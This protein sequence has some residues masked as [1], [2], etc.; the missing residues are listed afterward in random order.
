MAR[1]AFI[2]LE[3]LDRAGKSTQVS[4]I[5]QALKERNV[6][7]ESRVFPGEIV[8]CYYCDKNLSSTCRLV[9]TQIMLVYRSDS[10][11]CNE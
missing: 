6:P 5:V 2:V 11:S 9:T 4:M 1:G 3:G 7:V 10:S 8:M